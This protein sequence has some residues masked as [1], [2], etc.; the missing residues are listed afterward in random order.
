MI[1]PRATATSTETISATKIA[2]TEIITNATQ[3]SSTQHQ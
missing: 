3:L 2:A 1:G